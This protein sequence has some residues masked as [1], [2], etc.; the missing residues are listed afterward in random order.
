[1]KILIQLSSV[2]YS[3][4]QN[5]HCYN[6]RIEVQ[7]DIPFLPRAE[8]LFDCDSII[9]EKMPIFFEGLSWDVS[10]ISYERI[11]GKITPIICLSGE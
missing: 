3:A 6:N 4:E 2:F 1:M 10:Y 5:Q 11:N 7:W 8:E 9:G